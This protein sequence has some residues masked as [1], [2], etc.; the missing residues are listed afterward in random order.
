PEPEIICLLA[1]TIEPALTPPH[2]NIISDR[3]CT[4]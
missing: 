4:C 3:H 1:I 2:Y